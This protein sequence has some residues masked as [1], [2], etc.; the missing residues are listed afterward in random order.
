VSVFGSC[1]ECGGPYFG[2]PVGD[3]E[4]DGV[5]HYRLMPAAAAAYREAWRIL[6]AF[7][8]ER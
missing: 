7:E 8:Q 6:V 5:A 2:S 4:L 1:P 3:A